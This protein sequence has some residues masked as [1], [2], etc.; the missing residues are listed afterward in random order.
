MSFKKQDLLIL[1][2]RVGS[3]RLFVGSALLI[4]L[5]FGVVFFL[6]CLR[7]VAVSIIVRFSGLRIH[8]RLK[9]TYMH[10]II[11]VFIVMGISACFKENCKRS[12]HVT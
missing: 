2:D 10:L 3:P 6:F 12:L 8:T 9:F 1:H 5:V 4:F 7:P 11:I